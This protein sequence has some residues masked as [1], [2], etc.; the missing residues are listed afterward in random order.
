MDEVAGHLGCVLGMIVESG[1]RGKY[2]RAGVGGELHVAQMN[3][4]EGSLSHAKDERAALLEAYIGG[5]VDEIG[6]QTIRDGG[7]GSHGAGKN[8]HGLGGVA[9]TGYAGSDVGVD[10]PVK[11]GAWESEEF[12]GEIVAAGEGKLFGEDAQRAFGC[13]EVNTGDAV[14]GGEG[15][16]HLRGIDAAAGSGD[17]EGDVAGWT[18]TGDY[19]LLTAETRPFWAFIG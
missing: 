16:Q 9:S 14:V 2:S 1:N 3:S 12:F 7:E 4:I 15:A 11:L 5:A 6:C 10:V 13:D 18:H 8:D 17:G 19:R